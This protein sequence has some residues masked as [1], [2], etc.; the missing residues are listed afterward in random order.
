ML[1]E[2]INNNGILLLT[3]ADYIYNNPAPEMITYALSK[4]M[5]HNLHLN[6]S[7]S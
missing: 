5:I 3:G 7:K 6:L 1:N 4:N 2:H